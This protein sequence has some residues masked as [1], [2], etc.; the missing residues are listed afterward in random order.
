MEALF[1]FMKALWGMPV[2]WRLWLA[3]IGGVN[4]FGLFFME[5]RQA[6]L[7][8]LALMGSFGLGVVVFKASGFTRLL[9]L[10]HIFW[11]ALIPFLWTSLPQIESET[12]GTWIRIVLITNAA[13]LVIDVIDVVRYIFGDRRD[14]RIAPK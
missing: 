9:G 13:C 8:L 14:L 7:T 2:G 6:Q 10:M 4:M 5:H 12:F 11:F 3:W 1:G